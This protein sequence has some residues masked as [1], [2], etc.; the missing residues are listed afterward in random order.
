[1]KTPQDDDNA[2][3]VSATVVLLYYGR[4]FGLPTL[5]YRFKKN[6]DLSIPKTNFQLIYWHIFQINR[7]M[8]AANF[9]S[10]M[11]LFGYIV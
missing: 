11:T 5:S 3:V 10:N 6:I 1:M 7:T 9:T 8:T 4:E 2:A